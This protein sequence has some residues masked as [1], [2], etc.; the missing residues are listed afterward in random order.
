MLEVSCSAVFRV[1]DRMAGKTVAI[2]PVD[3][4]IGQSSRR[5]QTDEGTIDQDHIVTKIR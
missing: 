1:D 3:H 5:E 2:S 4:A